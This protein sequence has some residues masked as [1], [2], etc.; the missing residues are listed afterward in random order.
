MS[1]TDLEKEF[2]SLKSEFVDLKSKIDILLQKYVSLEKRY[3][4]SASRKNKACFKCKVCEEECENL[5]EL[6]NHKKEHKS[7]LPFLHC[8]KKFREEKQL[9]Q[10]KKT[11]L[12]F[13]CDECD[14]I[15]DFEVN[16]E[17]HK[18]AVHEDVTLYCHYF[19]NNKE[20]P[21]DEQCIYLHEESEKCKFGKLCERNLCMYIHDVEDDEDDSDSDA[22]DDDE[23]SVDTLQPQL[24]KLKEAVEKF[25]T[26]LKK[27]K[28]NLK[29]KQCEFEARNQNGM[30]MH[31]K[32]K[33]TNKS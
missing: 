23:I 15:F 30:T 3:E 21:Y 27:E 20:C 8:D 25:D 4:K 6:K 26:L 29:C 24:E 19:N 32:A 28:N 5:K 1:A 9:T 14:K 12:E 22:D 17:K 33:H 16:L 11:H 10:H 13:E 7:C 2:S 18:E 31:V